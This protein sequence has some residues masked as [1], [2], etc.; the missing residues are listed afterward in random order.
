MYVL[1]I[2]C[3]LG[4]KIKSEEPGLVQIACVTVLKTSPSPDHG[5]S[6]WPGISLPTRSLRSRHAHNRRANADYLQRLPV[7]QRHTPRTTRSSP[8]PVRLHP[9]ATYVGT[10]RTS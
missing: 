3:F 7:S 1:R 5:D 4:H 10:P 2:P 9:Q 8:E 6:Q